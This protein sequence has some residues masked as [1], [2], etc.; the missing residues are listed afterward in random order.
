[1]RSQP[2]ILTLILMLFIFWIGVA[3]SLFIF[4]SS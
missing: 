3:W 4:F 1:M 2:L